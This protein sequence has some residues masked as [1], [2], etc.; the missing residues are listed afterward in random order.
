[1]RPN[2]PFFTLEEVKILSLKIIGSNFFS[3]Y[4][5]TRQL[6]DRI[7]VDKYKIPE[8]CLFTESE[9]TPLQKFIKKQLNHV[10]RDFKKLEYIWKYSNRFWQIMDKERINTDPRLINE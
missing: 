9:Y 5:S 3:K 8:R 4:F 10:M 2:I 1:M 6:A 7:I